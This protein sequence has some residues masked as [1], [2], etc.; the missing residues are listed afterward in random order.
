MISDIALWISLVFFILLAFAGRQSSKRNAALMAFLVFAFLGSLYQ[1]MQYLQSTLTFGPVITYIL[2]NMAP[3][4]MYAVWVPSA[5]VFFNAAATARTSLVRT[6]SLM[7]AIGLL[8]ITFSW[9]FRLLAAQPSFLTVSLVSVA[10][11][12]LLLGGVIYR[13]R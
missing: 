1:V 9:A 6:R 8:L 11:F 2:A 7:F 10:G 4:L 13:A 3:L 5:L 12:G